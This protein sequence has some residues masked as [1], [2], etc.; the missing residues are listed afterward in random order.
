MIAKVVFTVNILQVTVISPFPM[1]NPP[2]NYT[3]IDIS[4][5]KKLFEGTANTVL[6]REIMQMNLITKFKFLYRNTLMMTNFTLQHPEMKKLLNSSQKFDLIIL[7]LFLTD[8]LLGLSTVYDCPVVALSANG[9]HTWVN[10]VL[11][12]PRPASYVPHMYTDFNTRMNL[13]KRLENEFFYFVEKMLMKI[14]HLPPQEELFNQVFPNSKMSFD[15]VRRNSVAIALV[16]SH[17]SISFPKPFLPNT[18]E[19]AGMQ[20][21]EAVLKPLPEDIREFIENSEHGVIYFSLGGNVKVSQMDE[22][23]KQDLI[24]AFSSLK[25]NV[26]WKYDGETLDVDPKKIMVRK[27]LPQ[28]EILGHS[29]TKLF[30]T[31]AGLLSVTEAIHFAKPVIAIPI[32]GDQPQNAKKC[33]NERYGIHLDY[34]NFTGVSVTWAVN[35]ILSNPM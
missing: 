28:Y 29:N 25:Q 32:F 7:D 9:P 35:E 3:P 6:T 1:E 27:W 24:K 34:F 16:N 20:I 18:I 10:D 15:E 26:I 14:Y 23:K 2:Q 5:M 8:A 19:V 4:D 33:A 11:G 12:S 22:E 17:F 31:H 21:N 13:G 30:I